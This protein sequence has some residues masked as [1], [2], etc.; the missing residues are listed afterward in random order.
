MWQGLSH[1]PVAAILRG[2]ADSQRRHHRARRSWQDDA[3]RRAPRRLRG[4]LERRHDGGRGDCTEHSVLFVAL[5]VVN[6]Q[7]L[8]SRVFRD[9]TANPDR[10]PA[11]ARTLLKW[12]ALVDAEI[13]GDVIDALAGEEGERAVTRLVINADYVQLG[14]SDVM[15]QISNCSFDAATWE[16]WGTL[17]NGGQID[18]FSGKPIGAG[19]GSGSRSSAL[20]TACSSGADSGSSSSTSRS[21]TSTAR[22]R[23]NVS[24]PVASAAT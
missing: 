14:A 2:Y 19:N 22:S 3:H 11:S 4:L 23:R 9:S 7:M 1:P 24:A 18:P 8:W 6:M 17:L 12:C 20:R 21:G 13:P 16:I 15:A 10:V 5:A